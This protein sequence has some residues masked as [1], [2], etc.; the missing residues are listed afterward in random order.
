MKHRIIF[1]CLLVL[2]GAQIT[3]AQVR[4]YS[5]EFLSIGVGARAFGMGNSQT[6]VV[7]DVT[8]GYWNPA[9][10]NFAPRIP[11]IALMHSEYFG[12][13]ATYDYGAISLPFDSLS[14]FGISVIRFGV[15]DIPN[16]LNILDDKTGLLNYDNVTTFSVSD[17]AFIFS[18]ARKTNFFFLK[19]TNLGISAKIINRNVG[20][21]ATAWGFGLDAGAIFQKDKWLIGLMFQDIT[22]T[23][24]AWSFN[25]ETFEDAFVKTGNEI[26][27][28]SI[29]ITLP[30][31]K[32]GIARNFKIGSK[33][34][35]LGSLDIETTFDGKRNTL[36]GFDPVSFDPRLGTEISYRDMLFLR[37][38]V[39]NIQHTYDDAGNKLLS[40]MPNMGLG[41]KRKMWSVDY[42]LSNVGNVSDALYSHV[43]SVKVMWDNNIFTQR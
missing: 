23:F 4:K 29:E 27:E 11:Q 40:V 35:V 20:P 14:H 12:G 36:V 28:N 13:I 2:F 1:S 16:T 33:F 34:N 10:L 43:I 24:N 15:D 32:S 25:T 31:I 22:S 39:N 17:Y 8:G 37:L 9:G 30:K 26:P 6:A 18:F 5:N 19:N 42:A 38:G 7:N 21:F 41:L 3:T